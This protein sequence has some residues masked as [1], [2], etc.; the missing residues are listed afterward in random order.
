MSDEASKQDVCTLCIQSLHD[1][2]HEMEQDGHIHAVADM[3]GEYD[4]RL[5]DM[6]EVQQSSEQRIED[7]VVNLRTLDD[8]AVC[9]G[10]VRCLS[11][12]VKKR[13]F[14]NCRNWRSS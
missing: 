9:D 4:S 8:H 7:I 13:V 3:R 6:T 1:S 2:L 14:R 10:N 11:P 12:L 5:R